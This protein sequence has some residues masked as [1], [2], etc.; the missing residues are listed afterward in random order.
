[1]GPTAKTFW[2][3]VLFHNG[4]KCTIYAACVVN[5]IGDKEPYSFL[6]RT[7]IPLIPGWAMSVHK[8]Q[9]MTLDR[10]I[11]DLSKAFV[12][13]QVYVALSRATGLEGLRIDGDREALMALF[14]GDRFVQDFLQNKFEVIPKQAG[15][16]YESR[17]VSSRIFWKVVLR[18]R[19]PR[20]QL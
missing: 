4:M 8:S 19:P 16:Y 9:G 20:T 5:A 2:P 11:V 3:R 1:M 12:A 18:P 10:V 7:Q 6:H 13:G 14:E 17:R 15:C